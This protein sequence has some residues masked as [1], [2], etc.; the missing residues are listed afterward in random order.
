MPRKFTYRI[1]GEDDTAT[2]TVIFPGERPRTATSAHPFFQQ[3]VQKALA[4]DE[5][6]RDMFNPATVVGTHFQRLG[7]RVTTV[8]GMIFYDGEP[9]DDSVTKQIL[10]IL[11]QGSP[12]DGDLEVLVKFYEKLQ[13][14]PNEHSRRML[15][16]YLNA[17]DYTLTP[18]GDVIGYKGV[19]SDGNGGYRSTSAGQ[20]IVDG[21]VISGKIPNAVGSLVEMPRDQVVHDPHNACSTGLHVGTFSYAESYGRGGCMLA[22]TINPRDVVSVPSDAS[23]EKMR[24]CRYVVADIIEDPYDEPVVDPTKKEP[25]PEAIEEAQANENATV[26]VTTEAVEPKPWWEKYFGKRK[27]RRHAH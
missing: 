5:S 2:V 21:V 9:V 15:Y 27:P 11:E 13:Q 25:T 3:I 10:R 4:D 22:V 12:D 18:D 14:N 26:M 17:H 6:I 20:A 19:E 23:G 24:V 7:D 16:D 1:T 8:N